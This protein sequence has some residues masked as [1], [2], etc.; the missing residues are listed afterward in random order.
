VNDDDEIALHDSINERVRRYDGRGK[1]LEEG[2]LWSLSDERP[3]RLCRS[4]LEGRLYLPDRS[5]WVDG[6]QARTAPGN[7][8]LTFGPYFNLKRAV[9]L[10]LDKKGKSLCVRSRR[11]KDPEIRPAGTRCADRVHQLGWNGRRLWATIG[12]LPLAPVADRPLPGTTCLCSRT[13]RA[14][15]SFPRCMPRW[16][17]PTG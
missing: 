4:A 12:R 3:P 16:E 1:L 14:T 6:A 7:E 10:A 13:R 5:R 9:A 15:A 2:S 8:V 17:W 11:E